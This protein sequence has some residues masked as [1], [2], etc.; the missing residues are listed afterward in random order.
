M[1]RSLVYFLIIAGV[2][3]VVFTLLS[4]NLG[5][6]NEL[7]INEVITMASRGQVEG[8]EVKGRLPHS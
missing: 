3:A 2:T 1:R 4:G 8:I 6:S 7:P 5:G